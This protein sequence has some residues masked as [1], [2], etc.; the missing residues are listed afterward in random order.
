MKVLSTTRPLLTSACIVALACIFGASISQTPANAF[1]H[2]SAITIAPQ[3][4]AAR[5][6]ALKVVDYQPHDHAWT[7]MWT[8]WRPTEFAADLQKIKA[9]GA[10]AIRL[11]V[12]PAA[13]GWPTP[14]GA[15]LTHFED[16]LA[17]ANAQGLQVQLTL[18][19][20]WTPYSYVASSKKWMT[21]LLAGHKDDPRIAMV[22][23]INEVDPYNA[24]QMSWLRQTM[25]TLHSLMGMIPTTVS[26]ST[27]AGVGA[28]STL[29][30]ALKP[31]GMT[32]A[33]IHYYGTGSGAWTWLSQAKT[34]AQGL[35][36][37]IGEAGYTTYRPE[38]PVMDQVEQ[39]QAQWYFTTMTAASSLGLSVAPYMY[40][41]LSTTADPQWATNPAPTS[42]LRFGIYRGDGT[43][44]P[45]VSTI[46]NLWAGT[47]ATTA[48]FNTDFAQRSSDGTA[49]GWHFSGYSGSA[50]WDGNVGHNAN[51]SVR[52]D[53]TGTDSVLTPSVVQPLP[54]I[55]RPGDTWT[56]SASVRLIHTGK[57][58]V[59]IAWYDGRGSWLGTASSTTSPSTAIAWNTLTV[60]AKAP[61]GAV[62]AD[63][64]LMDALN[65]GSVW[66]DDVTY[67][68]TSP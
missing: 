13:T 43:A 7:S 11:C 3:N 31:Y 68:R 42:E 58:R 9:L 8:D 41:D 16:A 37:F 28:L 34:A 67:Q 44:R 35:P 29:V 19:D 61:A 2:A 30:T 49:L 4:T 12:Y 63:A 45:A 24:T 33:D 48:T 52:F 6:A 66:F 17:I 14:Q 60:Q 38:T 26:V 62:Q 51:G 5:V 22:E 64:M 10:N 25:P 56:L 53:N 23:L 46:R 1:T 32:A 27:T 65:P 40:I 59:S 55:V 57:I 47:S 21:T 50:V 39:T 36:L 18:F 54:G 20:W 15:G